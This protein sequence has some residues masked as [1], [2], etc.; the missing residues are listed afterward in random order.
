MLEVACLEMGKLTTLV[1]CLERGKV[2]LLCRTDKGDTMLLVDCCNNVGTGLVDMGVE[3]LAVRIEVNS[4]PI[5]GLE[6]DNE[7]CRL[8][9]TEVKG[10]QLWTGAD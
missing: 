8:E 1:G 5:S 9:S 4:A 10:K 6:S 3:G 7:P 2:R